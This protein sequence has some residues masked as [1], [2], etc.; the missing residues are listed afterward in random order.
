MKRIRSLLEWTG[1]TSIDIGAAP[2]PNHAHGHRSIR[3]G[4]HARAPGAAAGSARARSPPLLPPDRVGGRT[5]DGGGG[6]GASDA[7]LEQLPRADRRRAGG[8]GGAP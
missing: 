5:A 2:Y 3:E 4:P 7:R 6:Q 8:G 1:R